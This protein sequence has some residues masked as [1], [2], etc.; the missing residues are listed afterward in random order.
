MS[1]LFSRKRV[2]GGLVAAGVLTVGLAAPAVAFAEDGTTPAPTPSTSSDSGT[3]APEQ[4]KRGAEQRGKLAEQLAEELGVPQ[5][6]VEAALAK[7]KEQHR[8]EWKERAEQ[9]GE[10]RGGQRGEGK[11]DAQSKADREAML[12]ERLDK[13]VSD[14]K[15]TQ[16]QADA[17]L[18]AVKAGVFPAFGGGH[19]W[20]GPKHG[21][22]AGAPAD[23]GESDMPATK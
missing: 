2:V 22:P 13:A 10:Q 3:T 6:K 16:E 5:D 12:K 19:G 1:S 8:A 11:P 20:G 14:G 9:R 21:G 4:D 7:I 23:G 18:A 17:I 15:L